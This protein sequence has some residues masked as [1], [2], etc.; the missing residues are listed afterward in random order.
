VLLRS[1]HLVRRWTVRGDMLCLFVR[2]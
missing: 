2:G 1:F